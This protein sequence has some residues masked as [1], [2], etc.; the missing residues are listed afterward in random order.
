MTVDP[1]GRPIDGQSISASVNADGRYVT[2][3]SSAPDH[4]PGLLLQE[5]TTFLRDLVEGTTVLVSQHSD[6]SPTREGSYDP[7]FD[8]SSI[9][10]STGDPLD[11]G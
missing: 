3:A 7:S 5:S 11:Q 1:A 10:F 9:T 8:G 6:G 4:V 2:F